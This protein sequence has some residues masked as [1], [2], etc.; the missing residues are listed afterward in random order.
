MPRAGEDRAGMRQEGHRLSC[1]A[2]YTVLYQIERD[3]GRGP[4]R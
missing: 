4:D 2:V 1:A 3:S